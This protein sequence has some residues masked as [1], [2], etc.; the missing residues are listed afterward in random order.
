MYDYTKTESPVQKLIRWLAGISGNNDPN[1]VLARLLLAFYVGGLALG[2]SVPGDRAVVKNRW[3]RL[4]LS[5]LSGLLGGILFYMATDMLDL[6]FVGLVV[7]GLVVAA[8]AAGL[9][10][11]GLNRA[12]H[13]FHCTH[14]VRSGGRAGDG[15]RGSP[16]AR[17]RIGLRRR[18]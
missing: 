16:Q 17:R 13:P 2:S 11:A 15:R 8:V 14:R 7:A 10:I 9:F 12:R 6:V 18:L 1:E 4:G 5:V 3:A